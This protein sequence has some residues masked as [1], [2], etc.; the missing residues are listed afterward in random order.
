[1]KT[2]WILSIV[3]IT[4]SSLG[5]GAFQNLDFEAATNVPAPGYSLAVTN[6]LPYWVAFSGTNPLSTIPC[7][8]STSIPAVGLVGTTNK[9]GIPFGHF[10]VSLHDFGSIS[11]TGL[12]PTNAE[13][14]LFDVIFGPPTPFAV[15][16]DGQN[17]SYMAIS[18]A[19]DS[20][21]QSYTIYGAEISAFAGQVEILTFSAVDGGTLDNI[22]FSPISIP[23]PSTISLICL[24]SGVLFCVRRN[25][26]GK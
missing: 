19:L 12:V 15:S 13:S 23:E 2:M 3:I 5:Q 21:G 16:L 6:A 24:G 25:C 14:L 1:M 9:T 11:Q 10:V 26:K 22:Q 8:D 18:N 7:N 4:G 20:D 17:L